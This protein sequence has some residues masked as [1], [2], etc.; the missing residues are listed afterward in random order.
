[1]VYLNNYSKQ[2]NESY[3]DRDLECIKFTFF[4]VL[5]KTRR[6]N[7][8]KTTEIILSQLKIQHFSATT[9]GKN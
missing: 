9:T 6:Q 5:M 8:R 3:F 7:V 2:S 4:L 1:M